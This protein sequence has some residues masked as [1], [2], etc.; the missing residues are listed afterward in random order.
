MEK[1]G[2][3]KPETR[4][5]NY[6][7]NPEVENSNSDEQRQQIELD[8]EFDGEVE[9][10]NG[11][12]AGDRSDN[13]DLI[14]GIFAMDTIN[15]SAISDN[16]DADSTITT[17]RSLLEDP[18]SPCEI[19]NI[20]STVA[21]KALSDITTPSCDLFGD[22]ENAEYIFDDSVLRKGDALDTTCAFCGEED[23]IVDNC[24]A[25]QVT[26]TLKPLPHMPGWFKDVLTNVC[27]R[28][29]GKI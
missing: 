12:K 21:K 11:H 17:D 24:T 7:E 29:K 4:P 26:S 9:D 3:S 1:G 25:D 6:T 16:D 8:D 5:Q 14:D 10:E 19:A 28:C 15:D 13:E 23:H 2:A 18:C 22:W 27:Y 20:D